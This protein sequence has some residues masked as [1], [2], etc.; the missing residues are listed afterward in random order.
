MPTNKPRLASGRVATPEEPTFDKTELGSEPTD[1]S[2]LDKTPIVVDVDGTLLRTDLTIESFL[3]FG[4]GQLAETRFL[5]SWILRGRAVLKRMISDRVE[6]A[7]NLLPYNDAVLE[8]LSS[9]REN[10]RPIYLASAADERYVKAIADHLGC[11][12]GVFGSDGTTNLASR[13]RAR[14]LLEKFGSNGFDY[15]GSGR[16]DS[17]V[18]AHA[19]HAYVVNAPAAVERRLLLDHADPNV[20]KKRKQKAQAYLKALRIH[21]WV[22]NLLV[23]V[24]LVADLRFDTS[25]I[26]ATSIAFLAFSFAAS[27]IYVFNDLIDLPHDRQHSTKRFRPFASGKIPITHGLV[28]APLSI[29]VGLGLGFGVSSAFCGMLILYLGITIAYSVR[30]KRVMILDVLILAAL[31]TVR[32]LSGSVAIDVNVFSPWLVG[33][34]LFFFLALAIVKRK[35]ELVGRGG[36]DS[37][38][39]PGRGYRG[40]DL[41]ILSGLAASSAFSAV[42]MLALYLNSDRVLGLYTS[43]EYLW[44]ICPLLLYWIGRVLVLSQRGE[45]HDDPVVFAVKDKASIVSGIGVLLTV[46]L[47]I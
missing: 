24:P 3:S 9:A 19:R 36:V 35:T 25:S 34:S 46:L 27:G 18:W 16:N 39:A 4:S 38:S 1:S 32:V 6:I 2:A 43:P 37:G 33:F 10:G 13:A 44:L 5:P 17:D 28:M 30:L 26:I 12:S 31:Y 15:I 8:F 40:E 22:K 14:R 21:Q 41:L 47:A 7:A 20:L 42:V 29:A 23:F 11:I 45:L